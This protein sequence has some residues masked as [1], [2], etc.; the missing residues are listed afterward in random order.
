MA[1]EEKNKVVQ[2]HDISHRGLFTRFT[3]FTPVYEQF[4]PTNRKKTKKINAN[5]APATL[6]LLIEAV[7]PLTVVGHL[8][9][10][11][12]QHMELFWVVQR[13]RLVPD[14]GEGGGGVGRPRGVGELHLVAVDGHGVL[15][16]L[17]IHTCHPTLNVE[18]AHKSEYHMVIITVVWGA[19]VCGNLV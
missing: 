19:G 4:I 14:D 1:E 2:T 17:G 12:K 3:K 16:Q 13:L 10:L 7:A 9:A 11:V 18:L 5:L 8:L 15:H 6:I